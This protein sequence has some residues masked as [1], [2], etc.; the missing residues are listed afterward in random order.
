MNNFICSRSVHHPLSSFA[1]THIP[2]SASKHLPTHQRISCM[3]LHP[4]P[5]ALLPVTDHSQLR[6]MYAALSRCKQSCL[7]S[8]TCCL[9]VT[10]TATQTAIWLLLF[11]CSGGASCSTSPACKCCFRMLRASPPRSIPSNCLHKITKSRYAVAS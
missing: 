1:T 5:A 10:T 8:F 6:N 3:H 4:S 7:T 11:Y 9:P 2:L